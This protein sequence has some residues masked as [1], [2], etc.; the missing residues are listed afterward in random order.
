MKFLYRFIIGIES[1]KNKWVTSKIG[2]DKK[3]TI[4]FE[5]D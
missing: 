2:V 5:I 3:L 4:V 1:P